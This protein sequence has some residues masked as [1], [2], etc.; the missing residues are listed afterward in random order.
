MAAAYGVLADL[1]LGEPT[2]EPHPVSAFGHLMAKVERRGYADTRA[3]GVAYC[4]VGAAIGA[5]AGV[6][7]GSTAVATYLSVA[8]RALV[9]AATEI[10]G[11]LESDDLG[12][13]RDLL[14]T[15]VGRDPSGLSSGGIAR[16]VIESVAENTVD[17]VVAPAL[18][19]SVGG[20]P[21]TLAYRA[22][23]TM[24]ATV[25]YRNERYRHVGWA[26]ARLDDVANYVPARV[27]AAL[28][29]AARPGSARALWRAVRHDAPA[30]PSPNAGV[31]EAAFAAA[32][33]IEHGGTTVYHD[34]VE[35]RP[36]LGV[37]RAPESADIAAAVELCSEV[38]ALLVVALMA[39]G[40]RR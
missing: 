24:D 11:A 5:G 9:D 4:A 3:A 36:T 1:A 32:L 31:A 13:A 20:A 27:T 14:P 19:A 21:A 15:L 8:H 25:G 23:N 12:R 28:V 34:R 29:L 16:A 7:L 18:W 40:R 10:G 38:T 37:G 35:H 22:L 26:S 6:A 33:G 39:S 17:A 30:H 2:V